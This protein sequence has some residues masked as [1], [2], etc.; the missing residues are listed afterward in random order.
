VRRG[1]IFLSALAQNWSRSCSGPSVRRL[2]CCQLDGMC[3]TD[4]VSHRDSSH[5]LYLR[6]ILRRR[7]QQFEH[8]A[9]FSAAVLSYSDIRLMNAYISRMHV[10]VPSQQPN[11][12]RNLAPCPHLRSEHPTRRRLPSCTRR[13]T[14]RTGETWPSCKPTSNRKGHGNRS[15]GRVSRPPSRLGLDL[16]GD[17]PDSRD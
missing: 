1:V 12:L 16:C 3:R 7:A 10:T 17:E 13:M 9:Q 14:R 2:A 11:P 15:S 6:P 8:D 4:G 5:I